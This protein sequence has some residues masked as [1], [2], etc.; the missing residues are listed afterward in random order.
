[1]CPTSLTPLIIANW[2]GPFTLVHAA[3]CTRQGKMLVC[4]HWT[5]IISRKWGW[6]CIP[7]PKSDIYNCLL[8]CLFLFCSIKPRDWLRRTVSKMTY[9]VSGGTWNLNS[10]NS[11]VVFGFCLSF[12]LTSVVVDAYIAMKLLAG[13]SGSCQNMHFSSL[14]LLHFLLPV[15]ELKT[16]QSIV[17]STKWMVNWFLFKLLCSF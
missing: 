15:Q 16:F 5:S 4:K 3:A 7:R 13:M 12:M 6:D 14:Q 2:T 10:V 9:F 17:H 11:V 1:M 8:L